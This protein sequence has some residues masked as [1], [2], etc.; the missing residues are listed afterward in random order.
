MNSGNSD[1][2]ELQLAYFLWNAPTDPVG[3]TCGDKNEITNNSVHWYNKG[4]TGFST[5][6]QLAKGCG[7]AN[8]SK[9]P[10]GINDYLSVTTIDPSLAFKNAVTLTDSHYINVNDSNS[11][12]A[13]IMENG[14]VLYEF[15][16]DAQYMDYDTASYFQ[17]QTMNGT[18]GGHAVAIIGWDDNYNKNKFNKYNGNTTIK[19]NNNGAWLAKNSWGTDFGNNGFFW[20]SYE[21]SSRYYDT[22]YSFLFEQGGRYSRIYNY[23]G[24][25]SYGQR[26]VSN[27]GSTANK[28]TIKGNQE[29]IAAVGFSTSSINT[30]YSIQLYKNPSTS[31]PASGTALL[32]T[33][34]S[35][36]AMYAGYHSVKLS[37]AVTVSKNDV[38]SVVVTYP[39]GGGYYFD[40]T[41][42][43]TDFH[44]VNVGSSGQSYYKLSSNDNWTDD[45]SSNSTINKTAR[46]KLYTYDITGGTYG[47]VYRLYQL[48]LGRTGSVEE[49]VNWK[50]LM[51]SDTKTAAQVVYGFIF[52]DEYQ[53]T[54]PSDSEYV[55]M[56]YHTLLNRNPDSEGK[57]YW[58]D[59]MSHGL[60]KRFV[61]RG[62]VNSTE[63]SSL[64]EDTYGITRGDIALTENRDLNPNVT[65]FVWNAY[66]IGLD[67]NPSISDLN[68]YT[69][70]ILDGTNEPKDVAMMVMFST[71]FINKNYTNAEFLTI[72]YRVLLGVEPD[73]TGYNYNLGLLN[74]GMTRLNMF[75]SFASSTAYYN[76]VSGLGIGQ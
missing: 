49:I 62:F 11:L 8:E 41:S 34:I 74:S 28:Y 48:I 32:A 65:R 37:Q 52:S 73:A 66:K 12:K 40:K 35:G 15:N 53:H 58:L 9:L 39:S 42:S 71:E 56:L 60:S 51:E 26:S 6:W 72:L 55:D 10:Y 13:A 59:H 54:N 27:G 68:N 22:A 44:Y 36:I 63:F 16:F 20:I 30:E 67:R 2:S 57:A 76:M 3:N 21:N 45:S 5:T 64:C 14:G 18:G 4:S 7:L 46:I 69:G 47:F 31:N 75:N 23:D 25:A 61:L 50:Q 70:S 29:R 19:P 38:V 24:T 33:P 1:L 43:S 17:P